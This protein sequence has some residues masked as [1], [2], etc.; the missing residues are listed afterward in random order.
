MC[1]GCHPDLAPGHLV[2]ADALIDQST[3]AGAHVY[4]A[5]G[6]HDRLAR[7]LAAKGLPVRQGLV[8]SRAQNVCA[9]ADKQR[10]HHETGALAL[11]MESAAAARAAHAA[12]VPA[13]VLRAICDP[14][15]RN[16]PPEVMAL[17][18]PDGQP[19]IGELC[20]R[21]MRKPGLIPDLLRLALDYRAALKSR[22]KAWPV[23]S[24]EL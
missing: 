9:A 22:G 11:D 20:K 23:I 17:L 16:L 24:G 2:R 13:L 14:A 15:R 7:A 10:L 8:L 1:G 3:C 6:Q 18:T 12:G 5:S 4:C 21:I 19:A